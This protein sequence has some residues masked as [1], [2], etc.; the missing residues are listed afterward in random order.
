[1]DTASLVSFPPLPMLTNGFIR[2]LTSCLLSAPYLQL[3]L[4]QYFPNCCSQP[5][6]LLFSCPSLISVWVT[7]A[8]EMGEIF[9]RRYC[10]TV[11]TAVNVMAMLIGRVCALLAWIYDAV[12]RDPWEPQRLHHEYDGLISFSSG[13]A[14]WGQWLAWTYSWII[15]SWTS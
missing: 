13:N 7:V 5:F 3:L 2:P 1:M 15:W 14:R 4:H 8:L 10:V 11:A 9:P 6:S 12:I